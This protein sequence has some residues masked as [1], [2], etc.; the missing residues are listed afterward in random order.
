MNRIVI[1]F[2]IALGI[3]AAHAADETAASHPALWRVTG[4]QSTVYLFGSVH[5]LSP[6]LM[7]R[8]ARIGRA[9]DRADTFFFETG[10][11]AAAIK[12]FVAT[13]A[14]LLPGQSLRALLPQDAQKN[15][16]DDFATLGVPEAALDGR[17]P[18][19]VTIAM[20]GLKNSRRGEAPTGVDISVM[21]DAASR[22][23]PQRYFETM[24]QQMA[25]IVPDDPKLELQSF[26]MFL[27]DFKKG[28]AD[29]GPMIDAWRAGDED[30]LADLLLRGFDKHPDA[31]KVLFDD[32]NKAWAAIL[33]NVLDHER[34]TF[35]VTVGA[36][37][38]VTE[39]GV[40]ALLK[41]DGYRIERL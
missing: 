15:L 33:K 11:D 39:R 2:V 23:K 38:L 27:R 16:D 32:R 17:R 8:D 21:G 13:K 9:I 29:T 1:A 25:L 30:R 18:W 20:I 26:E 36:G 37:H 28:G 4:R 10:F 34:G 7:W 35:F 24:Q 31:R 14:M 5:I 40:P 3:G 41:H 12:Q 19:F 22:G 6:T